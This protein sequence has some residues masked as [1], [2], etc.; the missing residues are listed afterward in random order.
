MMTDS[1]TISNTFSL[2]GSYRMMIAGGQF[3][4]AFDANMTLNPIG[5]VDASGILNVSSAGVYG[6]L[7]L[8]RKIPAGVTGNLRR[9]AAGT[10]HTRRRRVDRTRPV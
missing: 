8:G 6:A 10:Q 4:I 2:T 5:T 3:E 1:V 9:H 7:Q